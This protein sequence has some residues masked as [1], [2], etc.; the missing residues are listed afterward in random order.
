MS[1]VVFSTCTTASLYPYMCRNIAHVH[2]N[3][4][5]RAIFGPSAQHITIDDCQF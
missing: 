3:Q 5:S 1:L 4:R 2:M